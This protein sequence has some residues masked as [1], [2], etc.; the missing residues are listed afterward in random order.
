MMLL[1]LQ[2]SE[3]QHFYNIV[4]CQLCTICAINMK[5]YDESFDDLHDLKLP[6]DCGLQLTVGS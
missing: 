2:Y 3:N 5:K 1:T 6:L 4:E